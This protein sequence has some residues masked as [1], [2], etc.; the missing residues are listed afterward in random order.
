[1]TTQPSWSDLIAEIIKTDL[2]NLNIPETQKEMRLQFIDATK[3]LFVNQD[4]QKAA[5][6]FS[7]IV[8]LIQNQNNHNLNV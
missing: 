2:N 4:E 5:M 3:E 6:H 7:N 1:M 8:S